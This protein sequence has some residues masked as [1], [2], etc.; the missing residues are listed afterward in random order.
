MPEHLVT[1]D[2][3][4]KG[5]NKETLK[6]KR[7]DTAQSHGGDSFRDALAAG[8]ATHPKRVSFWVD[9]PSAQSTINYSNRLVAGPSTEPVS[10]PSTLRI[11]DDHHPSWT[12]NT[13]DNMRQNEGRPVK[14]NG[15]GSR[16]PIVRGSRS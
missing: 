2:P 9:Q 14:S 8:M 11:G 4:D 6:R 1:T 7:T 5:K 3:K 16:T 13:V 15:P 10:G 12:I